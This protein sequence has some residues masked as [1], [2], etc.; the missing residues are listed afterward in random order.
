[1]KK[2][3]ALCVLLSFLLTGC[4][5]REEL[6]FLRSHKSRDKKDDDAIVEDMAQPEK[7][8]NDFLEN[9]FGPE[10]TDSMPVPEEMIGD[11]TLHFDGLYCYIQNAEQETNSVNYVFR[12][13]EDGTVISATI[14]RSSADQSLFPAASWFNKDNADVSRGTYSINGNEI[15]FS[16]T[17]SV[18]TVDYEGTLE[19]GKMIL[20]SYSH[21]NGFQ[22]EDR[23][24]VFY[25]DKEIEKSR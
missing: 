17:S 4:S 14:G 19:N 1:M 5:L 15:V 21:I 10:D 20:D 12:F 6:P 3:C 8:A 11:D 23:E 2:L 18:G 7:T 9:L 13:Y 16:S 24:Y 25:S 22:S